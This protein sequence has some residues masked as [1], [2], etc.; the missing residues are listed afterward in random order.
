MHFH[1]RLCRAWAVAFVITGLSFA[2]AP[3]R[4]AELLDMLARSVGLTPGYAGAVAHSS[5]W[6]PLSL[7]LMT[8]LVY[9]AWQAGR[10]AAPREPLDALLLSK[11]TSTLVFA[12]F[13]LSAFSGWWLCAGADGF[14]AVTLLATRP[15]TQDR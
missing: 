15:T 10:P 6:F 2:S 1:Q 9:L 14:V 3:A 5:L 11:F 8:T 7:S 13:A 4:V 12:L